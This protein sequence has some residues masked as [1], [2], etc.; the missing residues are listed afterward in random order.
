[1][2]VVKSAM[3]NTNNETDLGFIATKLSTQFHYSKSL[4]YHWLSSLGIEETITLLQ[5]LHE[6]YENLWV[7]VDITRT[8]V[9]SVVEILEEMELSVH[10]HPNFSDILLVPVEKRSLNTLDT[11]L[12]CL[13]LFKLWESLSVWKA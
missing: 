6:P 4:I 9:D 2:S 5:K 7:Q 12:W 3:H 11:E 10:K 1:M 8:D 13:V